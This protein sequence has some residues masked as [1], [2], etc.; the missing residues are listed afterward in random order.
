MA[1]TERSYPRRQYTDTWFTCI[2]DPFKLCSFYYSHVE[3]LSWSGVWIS[4]IRYFLIFNNSCL[5]LI[6][7]YLS[8][9]EVN[10][11][12]AFCCC[13]SKRNL[14]KITTKGS[15]PGQ[16]SL[17]MQRLGRPGWLLPI[18]ISLV[19]ALA[20][21]DWSKGRIYAGW[22]N[23]RINRKLVLFFLRS[24]SFHWVPSYLYTAAS[25]LYTQQSVEGSTQGWKRRDP[26]VTTLQMI[27]QAA[28]S[29]AESTVPLP[30]PTPPQVKERTAATVTA[31]ELV[32]TWSVLISTINRP[33]A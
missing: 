7:S 1:Y 16:H 26:P 25:C 6:L 32:H 17:S 11:I 28:A 33:D 27:R 21:G 8:A 30:H 15:G 18:V 3:N 24:Q 13:E 20:I 23:I 9:R 22:L 2:L 19:V 10:I 4:P 29:Q 14:V 31:R 5:M 12:Q